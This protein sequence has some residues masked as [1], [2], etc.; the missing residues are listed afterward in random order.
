MKSIIKHF[1]F[2]KS[3]RLALFIFLFFL[4]LIIL[5][6]HLFKKQP[7]LVQYDYPEVHTNWVSIDSVK[8]EK[9][10]ASI[11]ETKS[12]QKSKRLK[13]KTPLHVNIN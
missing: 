8:Q 9:I 1:Y 6:F 10:R 13:T 3:E 4:L 5:G 7:D 11:G 12:Y 2:N